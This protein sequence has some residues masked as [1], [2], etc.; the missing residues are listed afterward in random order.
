MQMPFT[1]PFLLHPPPA[2]VTTLIAN[3][4]DTLMPVLILLHAIIHIENV[5]LLI[6]F[7]MQT[8]STSNLQHPQSVNP[9]STV[10]LVEQ[11]FMMP[12]ILYL[13]QLTTNPSPTQRHILSERNSV[14]NSKKVQ[15]SPPQSPLPFAYLSVTVGHLPVRRRNADRRPQ[16]VSKE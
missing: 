8:S 6:S 10:A 16:T 1:T 11:H 2:P 7:S 15:A 12:V 9:V 5:L 4:C 14:L 13:M 3:A